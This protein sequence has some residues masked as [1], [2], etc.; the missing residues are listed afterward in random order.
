MERHTGGR[1]LHRAVHALRAALLGPDHP[2]TLRSAVGLSRCL[3]LLGDPAMAL[4]IPEEPIRWNATAPDT[5][6]AG[7]RHTL[8]GTVY[9]NGAPDTGF[10][11]PVEVTVRE[12]DIRRHYITNCLGGIP[13]DLDAVRSG[14]GNLEEIAPRLSHCPSVDRCRRT[15]S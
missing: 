10:N 2:D 5:L 11:G 8:R 14:T 12:P 9:A 13:V 3:N 7:L 1:D 6:V 15:A 4:A